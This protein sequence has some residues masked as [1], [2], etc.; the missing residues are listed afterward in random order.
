MEIE[1][2]PIPSAE[3]ELLLNLP[4][5]NLIVDVGAR[6]DVS[7]LAIVPEVT[8]HAFEP[9]PE[10]FA[11]LKE[12][13]GTR[14][15]TYLNNWAIGDMIEKRPYDPGTQSFLLPVTN[16][17]L[18]IKRLDPYIEEHKI[19][20]IDFLKVDTEGYD[21]RVLAGNPRTVARCRYIQ[22]EHWD[23]Q[24]PFHAL[25]EHSFDMEYVGYR[26]VLCINRR[27]VTLAERQWVRAFIAEKGYAK[28][29]W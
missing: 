15:N 22:Y 2:T 11:A 23:Y 3:L 12:K 26:N 19:E 17:A 24:D 18:E 13:V 14:A 21:L 20:Q 7:Y 10:F 1:H 28:L 8:L 9:N 29:A 5:I 6:T 4:D 25:L 27:L 16:E